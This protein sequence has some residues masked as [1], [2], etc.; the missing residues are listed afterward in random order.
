MQPTCWKIQMRRQLRYGGNVASKMMPK[1]HTHTHT[2]TH[3]HWRH[4]KSNV[5]LCI[6][7]TCLRIF[8]F[9]FL[10]S[11]H[12][13]LPAELWH[14]PIWAL[15][16]FTP[17]IKVYICRHIYT[18]IQSKIDNSKSRTADFLKNCSSWEGN[19][20][21]P[22]NYYLAL[23]SW[24]LSSAIIRY[25]RLRLCWTDASADLGTRTDSGPLEPPQ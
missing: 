11:F 20:C 19:S 18:R 16:H 10:F 9:F 1:K 23:S 21:C 8:A 2:H 5:A 15:E 6:Y 25:H 7:L 24:V 14:Y 3:T 22:L 12:H 13:F 4:N 17:P